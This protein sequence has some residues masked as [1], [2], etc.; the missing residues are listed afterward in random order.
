MLPPAF[1]SCAHHAPVRLAAGT[2]PPP[3]SGGGGRAGV[4]APAAGLR[5]GG[6]APAGWL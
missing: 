1:A 5:A 6:L 3:A 4:T 2:V